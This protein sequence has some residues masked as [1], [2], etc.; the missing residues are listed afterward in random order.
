M[1][2]IKALPITCNVNKECE[3]E[4]TVGSLEEHVATCDFVLCPCPKQCMGDDSI[5]MR[6][7]LDEHLKNHCPNRDHECPYCGEKG[8]YVN[9]TQDHDM[10]CA[11]KPLPCPN[12]GCGD[13]VERQEVPEHVSK[14]PHTVIACKYKGI[15][16]DAE[17]ER[18]DMAA[19]EQDDKLHLHMALDTVT[20]Q[21]DAMNQQQDAIKQQQ[22]T[23][24]T[25]QD[26]IK[27]QQGAIESL[28]ATTVQQQD[29]IHATT[30]QQ[31]GAIN[32]I[33]ATTKQQ[34]GAINSIQATTKQQQ[35]AINS[36]QAT[37]KQQQ[38]T[39]NSIQATTKQ[40]QG[41]INSIQATTKQQQGT[42]N[43][44]QPTTKQQE[45]D[46]KL[47]QATTKQQEGDIKLIQA[48]TKQQG[49]DIKLIQATTK[50]QGGDIK[51]IQATTK[52]QKGAID[53]VQATTKQQQGTLESMQT[54]TRQQ[55]NAINSLEY[56]IKLWSIEFHTVSFA[57]TNYWIKKFRN[58][59]FV[60]P[61]FYTSPNGYNMAI[62]VYVNGAAGEAEG[63]HV[64][65]YT[66]V[67]EGKYDAELEW[68]LVG[69]V[70][71]TLLNQLENDHHYTV[72]AHFTP[73]DNVL[74]GHIGLGQP[75]FI[76][77]HE[78]DHDRVKNTQYLK[79]D[80]LYFRASVEVA[81]HKPWLQCTIQQ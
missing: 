8:T 26:T 42:I 16:C 50:Q 13:T 27:Q 41:A 33:Q 30:K 25:L 2:E 32:S 35:G 66:C 78:L 22:V 70:K 21:Q 29:L 51:L 4:G 53:S 76:S 34:Q 7:Y 65:V 77:H 12:S 61:P 67:L 20:S 58:E 80:T 43:S 37:T 15:G 62:L 57:L 59:T 5:V 44:I 68:P 19:H 45:G 69:S 23:I 11:K 74:A 39:I 1:R 55:Q 31:Q 47:I 60:S 72:A 10:V 56:N 38:G 9:I 40:Q 63:T 18:K 75:K 73:T 14:C 36:I 28:Q 24:D 52:Q 49:G 46:I 3:W 48:T 81:D 6:K 17:L 54:T 79:D 64:S 71:I